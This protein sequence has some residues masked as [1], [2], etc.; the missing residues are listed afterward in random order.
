MNCL[1]PGSQSPRV[2]DLLKTSK[3]EGS[4]DQFPCLDY[5]IVPKLPPVVPFSTTQ[6]PLL[7][8]SYPLKNSLP[9]YFH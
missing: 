4:R 6:S 5:W 8:V 7:P 3:I 2:C 9:S 1:H